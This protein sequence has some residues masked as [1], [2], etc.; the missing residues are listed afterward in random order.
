MG[1]IDHAISLFAHCI[2]LVCVW[3]LYRLIVKDGE[4]GNI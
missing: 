1:W 3:R 2:M 4:E